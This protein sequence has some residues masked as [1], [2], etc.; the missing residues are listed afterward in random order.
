MS[1]LLAADSA[2]LQNETAAP[3]TPYRAWSALR[4]RPTFWIT[5]GA[6]VT[7]TMM[8]TAPGLFAG[9]FGHGN[10][11]ACNLADSAAGPAAGHPFGFDMQGCDEYANVIYGARNSISVGLVTTGISFVAGVALGSVSGYYGRLIDALISRISDVLFG[12][13]FLLGAIVI[14]STFQIRS[15]LSVSLVLALFISPTLIRVMRSAVLPVTGAD[16]LLVA[17]TLGA[18]DFHL[19]RKHVLPN[20][21]APMIA[22]TMV[23]VGSVIGAEAVLTFLGVGLQYPAISWGLQMSNA[24]SS[25]QIHPHLLAFPAAF[26]SITVLCFVVLG[27]VLQDAMDPRSR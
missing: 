21:L 14:L 6:L 7:L 13:P 8:A 23:T 15:V 20:A 11:L 19:I 25:F 26:L 9:W 24:Q 5:S 12:F 1:D 3:E 4:R 22:V 2:A 10:P 27:D 17:R 18:S 16:Y